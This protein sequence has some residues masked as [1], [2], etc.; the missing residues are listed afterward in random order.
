[1]INDGK[2]KLRIF[3]EPLGRPISAKWSIGINL[4]H[5]MD[6]TYLCINLFAWQ[7]CIGK[8]YKEDQTDA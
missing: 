3:F 6:E 2:T 7:I 8:M 1:M 4:S 5:W